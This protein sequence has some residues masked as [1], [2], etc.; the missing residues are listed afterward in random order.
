MA[1]S[2]VHGLNRFAEY[3]DGLEDCYTV[4]GGTACDILL[5]DADLDFRA[6]KDIDVILIIENRLPEVVSAVWRLVR[7]GGYNCGWKSSESV[8]FYRFTN[9]SVVGFPIVLELFSRA[10]SF[11]KEP[12]GLTIVPLPAGDEVSSLSAI[13][14]DDDYYTYMKSGRKMINGVTVLDEVH[15]VPFKAKAYLDLSKRR[16]DGERVDSSDIKKHKK[17]VFRLL[18]LF[19]PQ[20]SSTLPE[21]IR[22]DMTEFCGKVHIEGVPLK[23]MGIPL[24]LEEGI[25]MLKRVYG[26]QE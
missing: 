14:L 2:E 8:H 17:D 26:L 22:A 4:I 11:I 24:T 16:A 6:T 1:V 13:L 19:T 21:S 25:E 3:M 23:Q 10:P 7:D 9:P 12:D 18:Q 5:N 20:T 15:L